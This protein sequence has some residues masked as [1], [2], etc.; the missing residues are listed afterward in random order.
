MQKLVLIVAIILPTA[1]V[2]EQY[3]CISDKA[4]GFNHDGVVWDETSLTTDSKYLV[5]FDT[6]SVS[7]FGKSEPIHSNCSKG[8]LDGKQIFHCKEN[9]G[10]FQ[11]SKDTLKFLNV[12]PYY[13]YVIDSTN[14]TPHIELGTCTKF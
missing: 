4:S 2:A 10:E 9:F 11:M 8:T 7:M 1:S 14:G 6:N 13:D 3:F 5:N 12:L